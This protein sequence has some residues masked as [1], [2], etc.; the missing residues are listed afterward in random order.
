VAESNNA[1]TA[2]AL[3]A[4]VERH[5]QGDG[6]ITLNVGG[7]EFYTLRST[8]QSNRVLALHVSRA[9]ANREITKDG[10]VFIDRD[11]KHF[12]LVLAYLRNTIENLDSTRLDAQTAKVTM[13]KTLSALALPKD[14]ASV[15]EVYVEASFYDIGPLK[16]KMLSHSY[17]AYLFGFFNKDGA[18]N[19]L[20]AAAKWAGWLRNIVL[21]LG[22]TGGTILM[23]LQDDYE[24][25]ARKVGPKKG[26]GNDT[27]RRP[28]E[29][30]EKTIT[31][32]VA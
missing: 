17:L 23:T 32:D 22:A 11:P 10:A 28:A 21:A 8:V 20:D 30:E 3:P 27:D 16:Q 13:T 26:A 9:E 19:P 7:T 4:I 2:T 1:T 18:M 29:K 14:A 25:L 24:W 6:F 15:S 31:A 5:G 12:D